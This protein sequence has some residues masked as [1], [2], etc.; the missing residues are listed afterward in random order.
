MAQ[1]P[2][3]FPPMSSP[4]AIAGA[5]PPA[6]LS[7]D[8]PQQAPTLISRLPLRYRV[9]LSFDMLFIINDSDL[10]ECPRGWQRWLPPL[11]ATLCQLSLTDL[12][13]EARRERALQAIRSDVDACATDLR[14]GRSVLHWACLLAHP[15]LVGLLLQHAAAAQV[16]QPD[17]QGRTP[18]DCV[19]ALRAEPGAARVVALLLSAGASLDRLPHAGADL[20]YL[21]DLDVPL[22]QRLLRAGVPVDGDLGRGSTPLVTACS[23]GL[24]AVAS[25]L[26]EAGADVRPCGPLHTSVLHHADMPVWLA[27]QLHRRGADVNARDLIGDTPLMLACA[28]GNTPLA[29]WLIAAGAR[30]EDVSDDGLGALDHAQRHAA[31]R[32][33]G[34][35]PAPADGSDA[36]TEG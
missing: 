11:A 12:S 25:V 8:P 28:E 23:R 27:E 26:L 20:L 21:P 18:L 10:P 30:V 35:Q 7:S 24:W 16:N 5:R 3:H 9:E 22:V 32:L 15:D 17:G 19:Q 36:P 2:T 4:V 33:P 31:E 29:R 1:A 34:G 6:P 14:Y 13:S